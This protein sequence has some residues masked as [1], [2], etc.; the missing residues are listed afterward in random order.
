[1]EGYIE[2]AGDAPKVIH[3]RAYLDNLMRILNLHQLA[4]D[5]HQL[6]L[7]CVDCDCEEGCLNYG[8]CNCES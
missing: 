1:M 3:T 5:K 7:F 8:E 4:P 6:R 2:A